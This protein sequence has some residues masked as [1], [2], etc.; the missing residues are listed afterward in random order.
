MR[1][2]FS[3]LMLYVCT[4]LHAHHNCRENLASA[5]KQLC[6]ISTLYKHY[7]SLATEPTPTRKVTRFTIGDT[8]AVDYVLTDTNFLLGAL[9]FSIPSNGSSITVRVSNGMLTGTST[10]TSAGTGDWTHA[11]SIIT[12]GQAF[13]VSAAAL[14]L[15]LD[16]GTTDPHGNPATPAIV[17]A[18]MASN[19]TTL[20]IGGYDTT[21]FYSFIVIGR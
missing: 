11:S 17:P 15:V 2:W 13:A 14:I 19:G 9:G 7:A 8:A 21:H 3:L 10:I 20:T 12:F 6:N 4:A 1:F 18:T 16:Y 5:L